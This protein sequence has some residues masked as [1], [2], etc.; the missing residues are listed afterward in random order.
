MSDPTPTPVAPL[1]AAPPP[2]IASPTGE[3]IIPPVVAKIALPIVAVAVGLT[4]APD[5][6]IVLPA[7]VL[8]IAKLTVLI[9]T[10]LGIVSPGARK[11]T[12]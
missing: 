1:V 2:A 6:G 4:M 11:P 5:V 9:G 7:I 3:A 10:L 8:T 12:V